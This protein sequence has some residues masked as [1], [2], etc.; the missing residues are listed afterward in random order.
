MIQK[1]YKANK[2]QFLA[3][4]STNSQYK[5]I[6]Y[7]YYISFNKKNNYIDLITNT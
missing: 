1:R 4:I 2:N 3:I 7:I 6:D 5:K